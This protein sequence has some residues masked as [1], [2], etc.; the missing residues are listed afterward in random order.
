MA[1]GKTYPDKIVKAKAKIV[2]PLVKS[3]DTNKGINITDDNT[4]GTHRTCVKS[5]VTVIVT[6]WQSVFSS[7]NNYNTFI[8]IIIII[9][10]IIII[11]KGP[12]EDYLQ[13]DRR[14]F[15]K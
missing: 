11:I 6:A 12:R 8:I 14:R 15:D 3:G 5:T 2:K 9:I 1:Q 7:I 10:F 4:V 13:G